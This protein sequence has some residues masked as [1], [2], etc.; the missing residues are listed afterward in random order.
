MHEI[1]TFL[2]EIGKKINAGQSRISPREKCRELFFGFTVH[3]LSHG[4]VGCAEHILHHRERRVPD[5]VPVTSRVS[6]PECLS[7]GKRELGE[8]VKRHQKI[9]FVGIDLLEDINDRNVVEVKA[10]PHFLS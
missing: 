9:C 6:Y 4:D 7:F 5:Q 8:T 1:E 10:Y 2:S 3:L